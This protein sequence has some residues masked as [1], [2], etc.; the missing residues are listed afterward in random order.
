MVGGYLAGELLG[1]ALQL[2]AAL[3]RALPILRDRVVRPVAD[4]LVELG[5]RRASLVPGGRLSMLPLHAA[6]FDAVTFIYIPS[7]GAMQAARGAVRERANLTPVL[8]GIGNPL[9]NPQPL[10]FA[11]TE[12]EE[13]ASLFAPQ[14]RRVLLER[15]ATRTAVAA[16]LPGATDLH[17]S[18]H[19]TFLM[20]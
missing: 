14:S 10:I 9:P 1:E 19:G 18:C 2:Q 16:S 20:F 6:S 11:R 3:D 17:F 8:L 12:V 7:A 13:I 5:F 15:H 4:R